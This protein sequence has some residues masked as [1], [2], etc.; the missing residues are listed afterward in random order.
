MRL[1]LR[2]T[3]GLASLM[4]ICL[5]FQHQKS[6]EN[7]GP[8]LVRFHQKWWPVWPHQA[9]PYY[10]PD[11]P[12]ETP[13]VWTPRL[14]GPP[15]EPVEI[16]RQD[17]PHGWKRPRGRPRKW[18]QDGLKDDL[19][20]RDVSLEEGYTLVLDR[21]G[22]RSL[23]FKSS[24]YHVSLLRYWHLHFASVKISLKLNTSIS[25]QWKMIE[26]DSERRV[27]SVL[28]GIWILSVF[29]NNFVSARAMVVGH[30]HICWLPWFCTLKIV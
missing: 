4:E 16:L 29:L 2:S 21:P 9:T 5:S 20:M 22:L 25:P 12:A 17:V 15:L 18:W 10:F 11:Q 19:K 13:A 28:W 14:P 7:R 1:R 8:L 30:Y 3:G 27:F 24:L 23:S 26:L 6:P